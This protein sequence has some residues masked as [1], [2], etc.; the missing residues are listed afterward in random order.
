MA[1]HMSEMENR[2]NERQMLMMAMRQGAGVDQ[3]AA[4][5][6]RLLQRAIEESKNDAQ[7]PDNPD[8]DRMTYEQ[9]MELGENAG[10][11]SR[12]YS[13]QEINRIQTQRWYRGKTTAEACLICME[14]FTSGGKVKVLKCGH[15]YDAS[16]IDTWLAKEKRC[17]VCSKPPF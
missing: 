9:L 6:E 16:C 4:E 5:E 3:A 7:D 13:M 11:V 8:V 1:M 14:S 12:G 17:P 15:E 2:N 10:Q